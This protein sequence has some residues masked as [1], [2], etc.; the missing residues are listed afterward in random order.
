MIT[1]KEYL[2]EAVQVDVEP[3]QSSQGKTPSGRGIWIFS[4]QKNPDRKELSDENI[5]F[6]VTSSTFK[7]A[8][9]KAQQ[10]FKDETRIFVL[11]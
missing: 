2:A 6:Q 5:T 8:K 10:H 1:F 3:F 11:P 7:D 9:K 4:T